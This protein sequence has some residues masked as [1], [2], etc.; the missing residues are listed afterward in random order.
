MAR[1]NTIERYRQIF[2][3]EACWMSIICEYAPDAGRLEDFLD[4]EGAAARSRP[5]LS[6]LA[7]CYHFISNYNPRIF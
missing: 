1:M 4:G 2:G 7:P 5:G 6:C 3:N